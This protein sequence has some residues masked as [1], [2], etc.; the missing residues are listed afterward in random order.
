VNIVKNG[1]TY[2]GKSRGKC[3]DCSRQFV[4]DR[5]NHSLSQEQK[6]LIEKLLLERLSL[7]GICR[8]LN[9]SAYLLYSY[10]DEVCQRV[11]EDLNA[12]VPADAQIELKVL[13]CEADE[14]WR[15]PLRSFV[16]NKANK[17]WLWPGW[18]SSGAGA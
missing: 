18:R 12:E 17:Q 10:M 16:A 15:P 6:Q 1:H 14:L 11:P 3:K 7:E 2:Y 4:F 9:I 13:E 5:Q 8:V